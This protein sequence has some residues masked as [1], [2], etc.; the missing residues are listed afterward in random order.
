MITVVL[1]VFLKMGQKHLCVVYFNCFHASD[2]MWRIKTSRGDTSCSPHLPVIG[3]TGRSLESEHNGLI[4]DGRWDL[5]LR[6]LGVKQGDRALPLL[7][8]C[9]LCNICNELWSMT[10]YFIHTSLSVTFPSTTSD[11]SLTF[12]RTTS[13]SLEISG[14][15]IW[16]SFLKV[17]GV[18]SWKIKSYGLWIENN[19]ERFV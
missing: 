14:T 3:V 17:K 18:G 19:H 8:L 16:L 7:L 2:D 10:N 9:N 13:S 5:G 11:W 15:I 4:M 1:F 6:T 12:S